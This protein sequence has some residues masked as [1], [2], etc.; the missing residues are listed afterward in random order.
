MK[1]IFD[2]PVSAGG[3]QQELGIRRQAGNEVRGF[4]NDKPKDEN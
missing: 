1:G 2:R 3:V 4:G